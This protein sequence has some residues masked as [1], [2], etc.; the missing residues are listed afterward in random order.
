[1]AGDSCLLNEGFG[2][3]LAGVSLS[4]ETL[5]MHS[6]EVGNLGGVLVHSK[7]RGNMERQWKGQRPS[8]GFAGIFPATGNSDLL[9]KFRVSEWGH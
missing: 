3:E 6:F 5:G 1:M 8:E 9:R 7:T 4:V 2:D